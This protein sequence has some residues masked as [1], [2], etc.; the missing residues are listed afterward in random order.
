VVVLAQRGLDGEEQVARGS[1]ARVAES[2]IVT[3]N[4]S[5]MDFLIREIL[6]AN[7]VAVADGPRHE[8]VDVVLVGDDERI[9]QVARRGARGERRHPTVQGARAVRAEREQ[10][11]RRTGD[12][13]AAAHRSVSF[14]AASPEFVAQGRAE[15]TAQDHGLHPRG[16]GLG[17]TLEG[18]AF[19]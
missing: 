12:P 10:R 6:V 1:R 13:V 2:A 3:Q 8:L 14:V 5:P 17:A 16:A 18:G 9:V 15:R 19:A 11:P 7:A 4:V